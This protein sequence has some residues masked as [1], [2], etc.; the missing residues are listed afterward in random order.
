VKLGAIA[1]VIVFCLQALPSAQFAVSHITGR[2]IDK[3]H[4][5]LPGVKVTVTLRDQARETVT[6]WE[7]RYE[8]KD[9]PA[10]KY[11][12]TAELRGLRTARRKILVRTASAAIADL[13]MGYCGPLVL[14]SVS[15]FTGPPLP[16]PFADAQVPA[17]SDILADLVIV[18]RSD[19][20]GSGSGCDRPR[21]T[22]WV[23][24]TLRGPGFGRTVPQRINLLLS[25]Y[26]QVEPGGEYVVW[27]A[28]R[29]KENA[30][31]GGVPYEGAVRRV[32]DGK[33]IAEGETYSIDEFFKMFE[34]VWQRTVR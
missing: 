2:I 32:E 21:Y 8:F 33:V 14:V 10:G 16:T 19:E 20:K 6:N 23:L 26:V 28:W 15:G 27:L 1:A 17:R 25:N 12:L 7:G 18:G 22:A 13:T 29:A 24:R 30:F 11:V 31:D 4:L 9:L 3:Q 34:N 5:P